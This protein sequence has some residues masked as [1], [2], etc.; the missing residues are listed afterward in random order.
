MILCAVES[1][2]FLRH[3][4]GAIVLTAGYHYPDSVER[5][6]QRLFLAAALEMLNVAL[7]V[8]KLLV[9]ASADLDVQNDLSPPDRSFIGSTIL[10]GDYCFSRSAQMAVMTENPKVVEIFA[11]ALQTLSEGNLRRQ[12]TGIDREYNEK[13]TLV[14]LG[15]MAAVELNK[16]SAEI[17]TKI[18]NVALQ[19]VAH[20]Q[21]HD[22]VAS[23]T[24]ILDIQSLPEPQQVRWRS[25]LVWLDRV[26]AT[27]SPIPHDTP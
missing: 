23:T 10:A 17:G 22:S 15:A 26:G 11:D 13:E 7:D 9:G 21:H 2:S 20:L 5:R 16:V 14:R 25:L 24:D 6:Q 19:L 27:Q 1:F 4:L 3:I 8:H 12:L 18:V